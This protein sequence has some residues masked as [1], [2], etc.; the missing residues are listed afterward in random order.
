MS[1]EHSLAF[2]FCHG[3]H[4]RH[5]VHFFYFENIGA[6]AAGK[7]NSHGITKNIAL[8][9]LRRWLFTSQ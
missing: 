1:D 8:A 7:T 3:T 6:E 9:N 2:P 5:L 4:N